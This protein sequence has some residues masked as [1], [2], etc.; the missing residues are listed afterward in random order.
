M[1]PWM[2]PDPPKVLVKHKRNASCNPKLYGVPYKE[3]AE[4][5]KEKPRPKEL[6]DPR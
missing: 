3:K 2:F 1:F 6:K 4:S 5:D